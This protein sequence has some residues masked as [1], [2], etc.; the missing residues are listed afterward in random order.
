MTLALY[1]NLGYALQQQG[2]WDEAITY[3]QRAR[4]LDPAS[5]EAEVMWA[6]ALYAQSR[7]PAADLER[8]AT[9][10]FSLGH[11]R[12][13]ANDIP[14][15]LDYYRQAVAMQPDWADAHYQLG[16]TLQRSEPV[17]WDEVIPCFQKALA[18]APD[19]AV[20]RA[21]LANARFAQGQL[22]PEERELYAGVNHDLATQHQQQGN[23]D[24]AA[25]YYRQATRL[26]PDWAEAHYNLGLAL[27][28]AHPGCP[29]AASIAYQT[30]QAL[31]PN[32][33][34]ADISLANLQFGQGTLPP[35]QLAVYANQNHE[36][37]HQCRQAGE[38]Q[39]AIDHYRQAIA[40]NPQ[41]VAARDSLRLALH[42]QSNVQIKVS[43]AKEPVLHPSS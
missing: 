31:D 35:E 14:S 3:Y 15:A 20:I 38:L 1:L 41:F 13:Q 27:Q 39:L 12:Q 43:V 26:R 16:A 25:E 7:L 9:L 10:N 36:L 34:K 18:L 28:K 37:G 17:A 8:Y 33:A 5:T 4:D 23:W 24:M 21:S 11:R 2:A 32:L 22:S 40:M 29:E 30:A 42:A 19:S 6:N